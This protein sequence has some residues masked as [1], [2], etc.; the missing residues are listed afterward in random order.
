MNKIRIIALAMAVAMLA[1]CMVSCGGGEKVSVI[2]DPDETVDVEKCDIILF[3]EAAEFVEDVVVLYDDKTPISKVN[4]L[5]E[6]TIKGGE[7]VLATKTSP[8][9]L[10]Y[11][12]IIKA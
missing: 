6:K 1:M 3:V 11:K 12:R 9:K 10:R 5:V 7:T 8:D 4:E 2:V